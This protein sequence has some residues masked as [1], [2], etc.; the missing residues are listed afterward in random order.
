MHLEVCSLSKFC[1]FLSVQAIYYNLD[2]K[3]NEQD[4]DYFD[5]KGY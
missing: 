5:T 4:F 3:K 2:E 1:G